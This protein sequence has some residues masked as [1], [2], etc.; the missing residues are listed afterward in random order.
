MDIASIYREIAMILRGLGAERIFLLASKI[1]KLGDRT[2]VSVE[3]IADTVP[4][5]AVALTRIQGICPDLDCRLL[6]GAED[7]NYDLWREAEED[8]IQL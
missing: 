4:D 1:R 2:C 6:D 5:M 7:A 3:V 8:G